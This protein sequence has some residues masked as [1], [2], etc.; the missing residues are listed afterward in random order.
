MKKGHPST[1]IGPHVSDDSDLPGN[2]ETNESSAHKVSARP[3]KNRIEAVTHEVELFTVGRS[4][5]NGPRKVRMSLSR[6]RWAER[7]L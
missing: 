7:G 4:L 5:S 2:S 1:A 6:V 3:H